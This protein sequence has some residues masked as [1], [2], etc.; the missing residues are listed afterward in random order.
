M[1]EFRTKNG[2][3]IY[4][5]RLWVRDGT[6]VEVVKD[7]EK[8]IQMWSSCDSNDLVSD[9]HEMCFGESNDVTHNKR[10]VYPHDTHV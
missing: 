2:W 3:T 5:K 10:T 1:N 7:E 9:V 6:R 8:V 4:P